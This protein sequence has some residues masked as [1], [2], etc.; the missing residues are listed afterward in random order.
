[1]ENTE[2]KRP[3]LVSV[4]Q[5]EALL[6]RLRQTDNIG[7]PPD[8]TDAEFETAMQYLLDTRR[9]LTMPLHYILFASLLLRRGLVV[10]PEGLREEV[11]RQAQIFDLQD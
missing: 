8:L 4:E 10:M 3:R 1:M 2:T 5:A 9:I 11:A 6:E 7:A